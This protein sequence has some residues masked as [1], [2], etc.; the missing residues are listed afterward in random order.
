MKL[1]KMQVSALADKIIDEIKQPIIDN[2][3]NVKESK[4][5]RQFW[6]RKDVQKVCEIA[7]NYGMDTQNYEVKRFVDQ[8]MDGYFSNKIK[9]IPYINKSFIESDIIVSTIEHDDLNSLIESIKLKYS[10]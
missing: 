10:K 3:K 8:M 7:V 5:Y 2:N 6:E 1:T 4:T 9:P